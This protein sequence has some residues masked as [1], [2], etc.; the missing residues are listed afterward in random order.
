MTSIS[1][2]GSAIGA[3]IAGPFAR[4]GKWRAIIISDVILSVGAAI[5]LIKNQYVILVGRFI[6]GMACGLFSVFCPLFINE[7]V[8]IEVKG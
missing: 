1:A 2:L 5:A 4:I 7:T 6:Y 8:P 3:I